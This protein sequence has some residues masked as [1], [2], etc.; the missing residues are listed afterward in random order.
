MCLLRIMLIEGR[1]QWGIIL[2][3][4]LDIGLQQLVI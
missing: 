3:T 1:I 2:V 4:G